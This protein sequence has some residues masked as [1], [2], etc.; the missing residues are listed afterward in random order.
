[1]GNTPLVRLTRLASG[2]RAEVW[3]KLE[4]ANPGGSVKDRPALWMVLAAEEGGIPAGAT[5]LDATSGNTGVALALVG[6][7]RGHPVELCMP[8]RVSLERKR[9][10]RAYGATLT[11]SD[12][13]EGTDGAILAAREKAGREPGR[14]VYLDQYGNPANPLSHERTTGPEIWAQ[15]GGRVTHFVAGVG[16]SGTIGGVSR[17]LRPQG[18]RIV[19]VQPDDALHGI[20]GWKHLPSALR[21]AIWDESLADVHTVVSTEAALAMTRRLA[22]EEGIFAGPSGGGAVAAALALAREQDGVV[23]VLIADGGDRYLSTPLWE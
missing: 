2:S 13:L 23:V 11:L 21:P 10:A 18:V 19:A 7:V 3:A 14:Y 1:M 8:D 17:A 4:S 5:L 16:T 9:I 12:P 6:A 20:E 15:T 22:R